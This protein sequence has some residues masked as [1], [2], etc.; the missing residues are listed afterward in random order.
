MNVAINLAKKSI[1]SSDES[2]REI[3]AEIERLSTTSGFVNNIISSVNKKHQNVFNTR[4]SALGINV[5]SVIKNEGISRYI[6]DKITENASLITKLDNDVRG[7]I[8]GAI[9]RSL[10]DP[11][12]NLR[13][14]INSVTRMS[15]ARSR[16]IARDQISKIQ[17]QLHAKRA[18]NIGIEEYI[19][20]TSI[21]ERVRDSHKNN[22]DKRFRFDTKP[23]KTGHPG[24]DIQCR[25]TAQSVINVEAVLQGT[26]TTK[27]LESYA[28]RRTK[29]N[30]K[31]A[32]VLKA[33]TLPL[34]S[35]TVAYV[36]SRSLHEK[37][38]KI[39]SIIS[40][41]TDLKQVK[42]NIVYVL[43]L[44]KGKR[45]IEASKYPAK[46]IKKSE[47]VLPKGINF[48]VIETW[49]TDGITYIKIR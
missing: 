30:E 16:L 22:N 25:C 14:E 3:A 27:A 6:G 17:N 18:T 36:A 44:K 40:A 43:E 9:N 47:I 4:I 32:A 37:T 41:Y 19:W 2:K 34:L 35:D 26:T 28:K 12:V 13:D 39:K 38:V 42:S 45:V 33:A 15:N 20:M 24:D 7:R 10:T 8:I 49:Q 31:V 48:K 5:S 21:D 29:Q 46:G 1:N 23:E 11:D